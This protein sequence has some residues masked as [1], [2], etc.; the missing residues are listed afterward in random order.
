MMLR[1]RRSLAAIP[2]SL[3]IGV[4]ACGGSEPPPAP[5]PPPPPPTA[6]M[7]PAPPPTPEPPPPEKPTLPDVAFGPATPSDAPK[8]APKVTIKSPTAEQTVA[9]DK[10]K[11][12]EVKLDVKDWAT[13]TGGPHVHL[14]L[15]NKP[16]K[17]IYDPKPGIKLSELL[18]GDSIAEGEH[19]LVAFPSRMNHESVKA[20]GALA[21]VHFWVGKKGKSE[22]KAKDPMLVYSRPKGAYNAS[23]AD[24]VLVD[25]YLANAELGEGKFT[26]KANVTGPGVEGDGRSLK[27]AEWKPYALD[28]LRNGEYKIAL[29]LDD[30]DGKAVPGAWNATTRTITINRDAPEDPPMM[31]PAPAAEKDKKKDDKAAADKPK[32]KPTD[33]AAADKPKDDKKPKAEEKK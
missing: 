29:E 2:L 19:L 14:I 24:H 26:I 9:A 22:W 23:K 10:A 5:P 7:P 12:F 31:P 17:P 28:N 25:W 21:M 32:D 3:V 8:K 33:K 20:Q 4:V 27:I 18:G 13:E 1:A 11:D 16:Y 30:K 15:D 6:E